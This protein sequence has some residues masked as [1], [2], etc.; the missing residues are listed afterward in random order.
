M[1][2][3]DTAVGA[4]LSTLDRFLPGWIAI[5]M[6]AGLLLGRLVPGVGRAVSAVEVDGISLPIAI[7]LLV[8]MYPVLAKVRYDQLD[9]V[10]GD[11]RLMVASVVLN[12][13]IGPAV[14]F[15][16]A[17]LML[18]DLPEYRTGL[19]IVGLA[20][21]IAMVIIWN[22][23]ACGDR[24]AA[25]VLVALN[26]IFQVV[27]FAALGWFY[28]SV[29]PGWLGLSTTGID[30]SAWHIAKSV[31]IFLG[32]PLLAGYLSRRL[33]E[34]TR[35]RGWY[36]SRFLPRIGPW[37]LY[38]LLFTIVILFALQGHQITSRPWDVARIAL[39]L[40]VYFAI[41]WAGGY[42]LGVLLRLGYARTTTLA[43]TAAGNNFE[44]AIAV[45]IATYGAASGQ[46]LAGVVGPLIEVPILVALVY[47]SLALRTR[48]FGDAGSAGAERPSVLFVCV[49]NA[50]RSQMAAALLSHLAGD[51]IEVLSA[52]TE[53][54][55]QIN[56]AAVA[57]MAEWG[58]D[59]TG[60][61][62]G[63][64]ADAVQSSDVVITMGC[65]DTCP[66]FPG[67]SY[68]DWRL[69]DPAG[70]PVETVRAIR[71]D[72]AEHVRALIEELLGT[73]KTIEIP[74]GKGR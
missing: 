63:L 17:W 22:D 58:I 34:R 70:Q 21:C 52:G 45:A 53:P 48:L 65:G 14:M 27:M 42:G 55:D 54:A 32:I 24:E 47:V 30:V 1:N 28:L 19:I 4:R 11:R 62:K 41:M 31:L 71:E 23:L 18:P 46:A 40:L 57:V 37:A 43:F 38:G 26:S 61:P 64:A 2:S 72:I 20:R 67:V 73:T 39:P 12:W 36:E 8:M 44:L 13:L 35:G 51:R 66:Y 50:G 9:S 29:L 56:P 16:L 5:A 6:V 10:T 7:G 68:R 3:I 69:R 59:I 60:I 15:A 74:T 33:G 25:A 49:H